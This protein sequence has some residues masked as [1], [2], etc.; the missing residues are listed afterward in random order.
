M[1]EP[2]NINC[3][4]HEIVKVP[5]P[6]HSEY[7]CKK[8]RGSIPLFL[9][10]APSPFL[11]FLFLLLLALP[12]LLSWDSQQY[13]RH[14][15]L[16]FASGRSRDCAKRGEHPFWQSCCCGGHTILWRFRLHSFDSHGA[17]I[18]IREYCGSRAAQARVSGKAV[19]S[20]EIGWYPIREGKAD[21]EIEAR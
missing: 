21:R 9:Y 12:P 20:S 15:A 5:S 6:L 8:G 14:S 11:V 7:K 18:C 17:K 19:K 1:V 13:S 4:F 3:Q 2:G 16:Y 10:F